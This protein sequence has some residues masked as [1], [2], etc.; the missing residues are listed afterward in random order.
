MSAEPSKLSLYELTLEGML[1]RDALIE[2]EGEI[3]PEIE[4]RLDALMEAG[5]ERVEAAAMVVRG[6][7]ASE[8]A[9]AAEAERF[10]KRAQQF[11]DNAAKLKERMA[12]VL[13][14]AFNGKIRTDKFTLWT[15]QSADT[16][17]FDVAD[18]HSIDEIQQ[19]EPSLVRVK[20]E[21]DKIALKERFKNG[22]PLP[23]AVQFTT[24]PGKRYVRIK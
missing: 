2:N 24:A 10:A 8:A 13:D 14:Y 6:L 19:A 15:Q 21:L 3:T 4:Q 20:K 18:G 1:I 22:Q 5:P 7:E 12:L 23:P 16:V 11:R 9:C 17:S